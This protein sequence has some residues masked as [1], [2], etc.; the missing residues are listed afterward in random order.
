MRRP[1]DAQAQ[2]LEQEMRLK[3]AAAHRGGEEHEMGSEQEAAER[4]RKSPN[5]T[6]LFGNFQY[7]WRYIVNS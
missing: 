6:G 5:K 2:L 1:R 3:K 7:S 4:R